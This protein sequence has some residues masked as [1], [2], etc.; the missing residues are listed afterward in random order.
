MQQP[1]RFGCRRLDRIGHGQRAG[2]PAVDR[3]EHHR[4]T[5]RAERIGA[6]GEADADEHRRGAD[7]SGLREV[8]GER[9]ERAPRERE[10]EVGVERPAEQLE[11]VG[12]DEEP[13]DHDEHPQPRGDLHGAVHAERDRAEEAD[14]GD[15]PERAVGDPGAQRP[16][17][18]L[19]ERVG[20]QAD[21]EEERDQALREPPPRDRRRQRGADRYEGQ[22][23]QRVGGVEQRPIVAPPTRRQ[24]VERGPPWIS[25]EA[26]PS[27][28]PT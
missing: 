27:A 13:S 7:P 9:G 21:R 19:V 22:V 26:D 25:H 6:G 20:G 15:R 28:R 18:H 17:V 23:P 5:L 3:G 24:C 16:V 8:T 1:D 4:L 14:A 11:V 10:P 12:H 2:G